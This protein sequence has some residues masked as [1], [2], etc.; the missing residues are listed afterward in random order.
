MSLSNSMDA[1]FCVEALKEAL[2]KHGK[3]E[4]FNTDSPRQPVYH[5]RLDRRIDGREDRDHHKRQRRLARQPH[6][7]KALAV[8][9]I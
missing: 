2:T 7:R 4:M 8:A 3:P 9:E 6:D 5:L 1:D